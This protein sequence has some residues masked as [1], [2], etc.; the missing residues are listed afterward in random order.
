MAAPLSIIIPTLNAADKI[1]PTLAC[2]ASAIGAGLIREL[3]I[4]DGGTGDSIADIA[5]Q[6]GAAYI[7]CS[8]SRGGQLRA[9]AAI[10]KGSWLLFLHADTLLEQKW[11]DSVASHLR[12][13]PNEAGYFTLKFAAPGKWP[14]LI[15]QWAN[16]RS[17][18]FHLPYGDQGLLIS[19]RHYNAIGGYRDIPL[20]EDVAIAR[21]IGRGMR[22]LGTSATTSAERYQRNGWLRHSLRNHILMLR[23]C[24]GADPSKLADH[25]K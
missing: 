3:I 4:A 1:G 14:N 16:L 17:R 25:Y 21:A 11:P 20:M 7:I 12:L 10:A 9:G 23:Y 5:D 19:R 6:A 2:L 22:A 24:L 8:P 15:A 13:H 18:L